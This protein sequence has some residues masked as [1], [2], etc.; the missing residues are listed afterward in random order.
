MNALHP[1]KVCT[2]VWVQW[3]DKITWKFNDG[4][5]VVTDH[6]LSTDAGRH[7]FAAEAEKL[8]FGHRRKII[9]AALRAEGGPQPAAIL[10][11]PL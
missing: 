8:G 10:Q 2:S 3:P 11:R 6:D 1:A 7:A 5:E 9:K 4:T